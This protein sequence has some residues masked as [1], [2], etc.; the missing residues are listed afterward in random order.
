[1]A[2]LVV[3]LMV[4]VSVGMLMGVSPGLM[5]V[6]LPV[7]AMGTTFMAMLVFMLIF[8]VATHRDFS[9]FFLHII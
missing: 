3:M 6:V 4:P 2:T 1:M 9:S 5:R 7:M 8:V